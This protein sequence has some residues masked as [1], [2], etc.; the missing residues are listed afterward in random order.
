[1]IAV[2][3]IDSGHEPATTRGRETKMDETKSAERHGRFRFIAEFGAN[4][5]AAI[6]LVGLSLGIGTYGYHHYARMAWI[7]AFANAAMM[8]TSMGPL[9]PLNDPAARIWGAC[10]ALYSGLA[11]AATTGLIIAPLVH[12]FVGRLHVRQ[13][14]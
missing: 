2:V 14:E 7:D 10:F 12:A 11:L 6:L 1:V 13:P 4:I 3:A 8:V 9:D 5:A